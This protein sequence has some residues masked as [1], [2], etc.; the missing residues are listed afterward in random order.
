MDIRI[1][2]T[3]VVPLFVLYIVQEDLEE[4]LAS[5]REESAKL[6]ERLK[7]KPLPCCIVMYCVCLY[8]FYKSFLHSCCTVAYLFSISSLFLPLQMKVVFMLILIQSDNHIGTV[9]S[10]VTFVQF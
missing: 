5:A 10:I 9:I 8:S 3:Y 7:V 4:K 6:T 1:F 2:K